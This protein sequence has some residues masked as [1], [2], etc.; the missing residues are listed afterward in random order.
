[1]NRKAFTLLLLIPFLLLAAPLPSWGEVTTVEKVLDGRTAF[2]WGRDFLVWAVHYPDDVVDPWVR[3]NTGGAGDPTGKM[4][5]EF[6]TSLKMDESTPVL[7][8]FHS[9]TERALELKPLSE[10][11]FIRTSDGE[12]LSPTSYDSL[13]DSPV[14]G[15]VQG[16]VFFPKVDGPFELVLIPDRG[17]ELTF[18]FPDDHDNRLKKEIT[19]EAE[20]RAQTAELIQAQEA[21]LK[22]K[23]SG[24][25]ELEEMQ[26]EWKKEKNELLKQ[27]EA[28]SSQKTLMRQRLD[29][30]LARLAK[31]T[32]PLFAD[33]QPQQTLP[34]VKKPV[35]EEPQQSV[36]PGFSRNQIVELFTTAWKRG[37]LEEMLSFLSPAFREEINGRDDLKALLKTKALPPKLPVDAKL[38]DKGEGEEAK[39]IFA[40]KL[41]VVR[42]LRSAKL[43]LSEFGRGWYISSFE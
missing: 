1:M 26:Q 31:P 18:E 17:K 19:R 20:K 30:A 15:L 23:D 25:E 12:K 38:E 34:E 36:V 7:L 43:K 9:Y 40:Q 29:E 14:T 6:R 5:E 2:R 32:Q 10:R 21:E 16:L 28:L 27:I 24:R 41:L 22:A 37:D 35:K 42:T 11:F 33:N 13:F 8:S 39:V 4:A 3:A